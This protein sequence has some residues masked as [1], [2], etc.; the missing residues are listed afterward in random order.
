MNKIAEATK[1]YEAARADKRASN[2]LRRQA[3]ER[4]EVLRNFCKEHG[5]E[6]ELITKT[7]G[8]N[9]HGR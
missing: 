6:F 8:V 3:A 1:M 7:E 2:R 9:F 4:M 5:I